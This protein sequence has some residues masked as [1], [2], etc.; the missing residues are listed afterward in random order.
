MY[1][2]PEKKE[3]VRL[4]SSGIIYIHALEHFMKN[5]IIPLVVDKKIL[6]KAYEKN[7]QLHR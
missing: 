6:K 2:C 3:T 1:L 4:S 7:A 5:A